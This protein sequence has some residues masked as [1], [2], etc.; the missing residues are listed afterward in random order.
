M[1]TLASRKME[2]GHPPAFSLNKAA[3]LN[4]TNGKDLIYLRCELETRFDVKNLSKQMRRYEVR[5]EDFLTK[6]QHSR[7]S[8]SFP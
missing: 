7:L 3:Y 1:L 2:G 5:N 6:A 4:E 8:Q